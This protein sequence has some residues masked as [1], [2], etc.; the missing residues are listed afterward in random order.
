MPARCKLSVVIPTYNRRNILSRTLPTVF[1]QD[2]SAD[3]Y[4]VI[5]VVDGATDG[6]VEMLRD[7]K[8]PCPF[9]VLEQSNRGQASARN[10]GL[11][12]ACGELVLFLDD[13]L[14]CDRFLFREHQAAHDGTDPVVVI[15][16]V[17]LAPESSCTTTTAYMK[18]TR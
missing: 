2:F 10:A 14:L 9:H 5:I 16:P 12:A 15:G 18:K 17:Y 1:R 8:P 7:L 3:E 13:D 11:Q 6:T 4:E